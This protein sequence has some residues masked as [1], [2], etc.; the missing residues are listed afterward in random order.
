MIQTIVKLRKDV[1]LGKIH[2]ILNILRKNY[3]YMIDLN[4]SRGVVVIISEKELSPATNRIL[5]FIG[6]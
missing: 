5:K 4:L 3:P 1:T 6:Q 2:H